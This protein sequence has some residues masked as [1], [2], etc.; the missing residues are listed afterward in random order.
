MS[1]PTRP[2]LKLTYRAVEL[3]L[4]LKR[5]EFYWANNCST[6]FPLLETDHNWEDADLY[7]SRRVLCDGRMSRE[8]FDAKWKVGDVISIGPY[9]IR[10]T[11][12]DE[13][14][15]IVWQ[16]ESNGAL[17]RSLLYP[18]GQWGFD[19]GTKIVL[20]LYV[21]GLADYPDEA[22]AWQYIKGL[23]RFKDD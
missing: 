7:V 20:T 9:T 11:K 19:I 12:L 3:P 23:R 21:W 1:N 4:S 13:Y 22:P 18:V 16:C 5:F 15:G 2:K 6:T 14:D 10:A 17:F 8:F